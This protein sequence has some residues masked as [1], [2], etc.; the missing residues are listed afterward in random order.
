MNML[1]LAATIAATHRWRCG[2]QTVA[3]SGAG[4]EL[5]AGLV[6]ERQ[7]FTLLSGTE[8]RREGVA[9]F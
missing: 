9:P 7:L 3:A 1:K 2:R 4:S 6:Q 8:D 5:Q